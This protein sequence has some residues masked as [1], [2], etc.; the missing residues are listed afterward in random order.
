VTISSGPLRDI[1]FIRD[2]SEM[3]QRRRQLP[4]VE[5]PCLSGRILCA[6]D[7]EVNRRLVDLLV[8]RTGAEIVHVS[9]GAEALEAVSR[10]AFDL[11]LMDIQMPLMNGRDATRAIREAGFNLPVVALTANVM[12]EDI[13]DY[14][15][16]G[17][18]DYLA[19]PIDKRRFYELLARYLQ[20]EDDGRAPRESQARFHGTVLVAEDND[21]NRR[22]VE[23]M[24]QRLGLDVIAVES[25]RTAVQ[26]ALSN[27]VQLVLMDSHMPEM[28]G[29]DATRMLRQTGFQ[30][31]IVAFT[32][33]DQQE[34]DALREAGCDGVLHKPINDRQLVCLLRRHLPSR[35]PEA[36]VDDEQDEAIQAL[37]R[38]FVEGL[39]ARLERMKRA[40]G[41]DDWETLRQEA[42]QIKGTAG[43]MGYPLMTEKAGDLERALKNNDEV[44]AKRLFP[45]LERLMD[46]AIRRREAPDT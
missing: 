9:N 44:A 42:H 46:D 11:V 35:A 7:N 45:A 16:A 22:L 29:P 15:D 40:L 2:A 17:C 19:K 34:I 33:G 24:L 13:Q 31:P 39:P 41:Q 43:A 4:M 27:S 38:Q 32:A 20:V 25:G 1:H 12:A 10:E 3:T 8:S 6:E 30:R 18:D 23:R 26:R 36:P 14:R 21:D 5:A 37:I 28:D